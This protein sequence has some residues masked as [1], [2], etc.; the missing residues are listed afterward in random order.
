MGGVLVKAKNFLVFQGDVG[1]IASKNALELTQLFEIVSGSGELQK[2]Y[3]QLKEKADKAEDE[4]LGTFEKKRNIV[5]EKKQMKEQKEEAERF[6]KLIEDQKEVKLE[7]FLWQLYN[8]VKDL[9]VNRQALE[10][11]KNELKGKENMFARLD[12]E[13]KTK[14]QKHAQIKKSVFGLER[15][16]NRKTKMMEKERPAQITLNEHIT[17]LK[18]T[19]KSGEG[20]I[21][22][23]QNSQRK[24]ET[25][26][27]NLETTLLQ[28]KKKMEEME[29]EEAGG[30]LQLA[31]DQVEEYNQ[32]KDLVGAK[33]SAFRQQIEKIKRAYRLDE[34]SVK[35]TEAQ[36]KTLESRKKQV[37]QNAVKLKDRHDKM[38]SHI[39]D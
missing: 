18:R 16:I 4:F 25:Q 14:Q 7:F 22:R 30:E 29:K 9:E 20:Q 19:V 21:E 23:L 27:K 35:N 6:K 33:S 8:V 13:V 1:S 37:K 34:D 17:F 5:K 15:K 39:N 24:K 32:L 12:H 38:L 11:V 36:L 10:A 28:V 31:A 2:D 26:I 3:V